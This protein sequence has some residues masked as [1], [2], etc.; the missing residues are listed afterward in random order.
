VCRT[1]GAFI[2]IKNASKT[3]KKKKKKKKQAPTRRDNG[4]ATMAVA[5]VAEVPTVLQCCSGSSVTVAVA[6]PGQ[7]R[8]Q[9]GSVDSMPLQQCDS[10]SCSARQC[11][12]QCSNSVWQHLKQCRQQ[13]IQS[14]SCKV[15]QCMA[16][17]AA[18]TAALRGSAQHN[19]SVAVLAHAGMCSSSGSSDSCT[20]WQQWQL[21]SLAAV[22]DRKFDSN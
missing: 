12:Q 17:V 16:A 21:H 13:W 10:C 19:S 4:S 18:A 3:A 2:Y 6:V 7:Q 14:D 20:F 9:C 11:W 15:Q 8:Q 1:T 22:A 5:A